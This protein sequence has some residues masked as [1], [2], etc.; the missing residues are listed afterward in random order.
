MIESGGVIDAGTFGA[1]NA[2]DIT[3]DATSLRLHSGGEITARGG[4]GNGGG[5][6]GVY[7][8]TVKIGPGRETGKEARG[9]T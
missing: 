4:T 8:D 1:G 3:I 9:S 6:V 5:A 2:G 7:A